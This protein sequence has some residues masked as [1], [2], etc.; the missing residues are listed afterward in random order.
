MK[1]IIV[2][3]DDFI[4][5]D[6]Y[7]ELFL[8]SGFEVVSADDGQDAWEKIQTNR[9]DLVFTGI[10]M[11]RMSGF[12]LVEKLRSDRLLNAVPVVMFSHLGRDTDKARASKM[13]NV[14]IMQKG[15]DNPSDILNYVREQLETRPQTFYSQRPTVVDD[16]DARPPGITF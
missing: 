13:F 3:D 4:Q 5:R 16:D 15:Y 9:P 1:R 12:E 10:D 14:R 7:T 8:A 6:L 11:P 2:V